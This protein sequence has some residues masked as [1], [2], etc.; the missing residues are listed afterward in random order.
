LSNY[1]EGTLSEFVLPAITLTIAI[2]AVVIYN[3]LVKYHHLVKEAWSGIDVQLK[4]RH[5]LLPKLVDVV[6]AY[7]HYE[8][9]T[10]SAVIQAR[11]NDAADEASLSREFRQILALVE[12]YPELKADQ[13]FLNLQQQLSELEEQIQ[14]ARRYYNGCVRRLNVAIDSFPSNLVARAFNFQHAS[15]FNIELATQ[16]ESPELNL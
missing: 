14:Y 1:S 8:C 11:Q 9:Q 5:S 6:K 7:A 13:S 16:R 4:R 2:A 10:L 15:Y 3:R 12:D